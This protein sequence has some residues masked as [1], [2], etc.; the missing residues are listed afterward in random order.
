M[1]SCVALS[2]EDYLK[3][4]YGIFA[5]LKKYYNT[6][7]VFDP[8][9]L[10]I[11]NSS[12]KKKDESCL[13]F[14]SIIKK[15]CKLY[16]SIPAHRGMGFIIIIKVDADYTRDTVTYKSRTEFILYLSNVPVYWYLK[17]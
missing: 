16:L 17:K 8:L 6:E 5:H 12:F 3:I 15:K 1:S 11:D 4:V 13:E 2:Y 9:K 10:I 14:S 7:I